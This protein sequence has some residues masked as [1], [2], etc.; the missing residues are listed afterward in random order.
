MDEVCITAKDMANGKWQ[1]AKS[2]TET[3]R[4]RDTEDKDKKAY[5]GFAQMNADLHGF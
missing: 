2:T 4:H 3:Q 1:M 5:R